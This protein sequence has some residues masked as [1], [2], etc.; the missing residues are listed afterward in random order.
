MNQNGKNVKFE[1]SHLRAVC[2]RGMTCS[3]VCLFVCLFC[4]VFLLN[5]YEIKNGF[6]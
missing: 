2:M 1:E 4:F 3:S 6:L 5:A